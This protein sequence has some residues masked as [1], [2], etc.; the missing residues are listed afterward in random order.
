MRV[1]VAWVDACMRVSV[2]VCVCTAHDRACVYTSHTYTTHTYNMQTHRGATTSAFALA[3]RSSVP[4]EF[5]LC[6]ATSKV[7]GCA[8]PTHTLERTQGCSAQAWPLVCRYGVVCR[9]PATRLVASA[10]DIQSGQWYSTT[11]GAIP[12]GGGGPHRPGDVVEKTGVCVCMRACAQRTHTTC[13]CTY[14]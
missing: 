4:P 14:V 7:A 13:V 10:G 3:V 9:Y 8:R 2:Y 12:A 5:L 11:K 6:R 1:C